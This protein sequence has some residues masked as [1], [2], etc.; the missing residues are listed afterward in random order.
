MHGDLCGAAV[1]EWLELPGE[2]E[3][4][5]QAGDDYSLLVVVHAEL[6]RDRTFGNACLVEDEFA[7][8]H[9]AVSM[10]CHQ[11]VKRLGS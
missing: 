9:L 1:V 11:S 7:V 3:V 8:A 10:P 6:V 5:E 4:V 2:E